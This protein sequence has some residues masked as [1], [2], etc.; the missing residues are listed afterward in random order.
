MAAMAEVAPPCAV[1]AGSLLSWRNA[2]AAR[3]KLDTANMD[4]N[5]LNKQIAELRKVRQFCGVGGGGSRLLLWS[6]C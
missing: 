1:V 2:P 5:K 6:M 4:F 3:G